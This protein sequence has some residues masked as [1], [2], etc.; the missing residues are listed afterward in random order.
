[1]ILRPLFQWRPTGGEDVTIM[2]Y[3]V[4]RGSEWNLILNVEMIPG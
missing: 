3:C 1:M 4:L 2:V